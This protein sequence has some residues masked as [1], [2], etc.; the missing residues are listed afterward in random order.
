MKTKFFWILPFLLMMGIFLSGCTQKK[1]F[2]NFDITLDVSGG[3]AGVRY[4]LTID[5][6]GIVS[7][8]YF[9]R[10]TTTK[11]SQLSDVELRELKKLVNDANVFSFK[12]EYSCEPSCVRDGYS[13]IITFIIDGEEKTIFIGDIGFNKKIPNDLIEIIH[14]IEE[15][16]YKFHAQE[17]EIE[18]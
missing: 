9:G 16:T 3:I 8:T 1:E 12:D 11:Q 17:Y 14:K 15:L 18:I 7:Y 6:D 2:S 13:G 4:K 5:N 10:H